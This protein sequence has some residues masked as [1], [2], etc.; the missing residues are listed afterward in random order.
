MGQTGTCNNMQHLVAPLV[1]LGLFCALY[2]DNNAQHWPSL[3]YQ[4]NVDHNAIPRDHND[5]LSISAEN[6]TNM[7]MAGIWYHCTSSVQKCFILLSIPYQNITMPMP[8]FGPFWAPR[9]IW[10]IIP[11]QGPQMLPWPFQLK[12]RWKCQRILMAATHCSRDVPYSC[13]YP[14]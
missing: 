13:L 11:P 6:G 10:T 14:I 5:A 3:S 8:S 7:K 12:N 9:G 2:S 1:F 4:R